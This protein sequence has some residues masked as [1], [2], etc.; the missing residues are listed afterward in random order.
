M[1]SGLH[2]DPRHGQPESPVHGPRGSRLQRP[3]RV[4]TRSSC[5]TISEIA[6]V[7]CFARATSTALS[8]GSQSLLFPVNEVAAVLFASLGIEAFS[9]RVVRAHV[10]AVPLALL[11]P[12]LPA[13]SVRVVRACGALVAAPIVHV[14]PMSHTVAGGTLVAGSVFLPLRL[15]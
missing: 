2:L 14:L 12:L 3:L 4:L 1:L 10:A 7:Q 13:F 9:V 15:L 8:G 11:F 6:K 5:S